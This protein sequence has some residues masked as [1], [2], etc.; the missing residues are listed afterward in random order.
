MRNKCVTYAL[1]FVVMYVERHVWRVAC[2]VDFS[3]QLVEEGGW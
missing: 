2:L 1:G 3:V